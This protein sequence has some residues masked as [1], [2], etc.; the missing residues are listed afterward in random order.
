MILDE[1]FQNADGRNSPLTY[2]GTKKWQNEK[3]FFKKWF[4]RPFL[5]GGYADQKIKEDIKDFEGIPQEKDYTCGLASIR[6]ILKYFKKPIPKEEELENIC[7]TSK[8]YGTYPEYIVK[9]LRKYG[10]SSKAKQIDVKLLKEYLNRK[11]PIIVLYNHIDSSGISEPHWSIAI[12][13]DKDGI[14][15]YDTYENTK[16]KYSWNEWN[17]FWVGSIEDKNYKN[18]AIII[19][20]RRPINEEG[21]IVKGVNTTNDVNVNSISIE[22]KKFG[23]KVNKDGYPIYSF[24]DSPNIAGKVK[25]DEVYIGDFG[26]ESNEITNSFK[27]LSNCKPLK[28]IEVNGKKIKICKY[29]N[30]YVV[31]IENMAY[32]IL[33]KNK[34]Y[35]FLQWTRNY[36]TPEARGQGL[37]LLLLKAAL[38]NNLNPIL[39]DDTFSLMNAKNFE[40]VI[41]DNS[42]KVKIFDTET[43]KILDYD[44][45]IPVYHS[46]EVEYLGNNSG[47]ALEDADRYLWLIG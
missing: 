40:K 15:I 45:N 17:N 23:N 44:K 3:D 13:Y 39:S 6:S 32:I 7:F 35:N 1:L 16:T 18:F 28:E 20:E 8:D 33:E 37:T 9:V 22:N 42:F 21:R 31:G 47:A 36:V 5:T 25:L 41:K 24:Y 2:Q 10:L 11:I 14:I 4:S 29:K 43:K 19:N 34:T 12:A 38:L 26:L 30:D 27:F 46:S